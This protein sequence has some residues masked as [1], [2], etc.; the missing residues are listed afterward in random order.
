MLCP[1]FQIPKKV[2]TY[3]MQVE[4]LHQ[5]GK[6]SITMKGFQERCLPRR[7]QDRRRRKGTWLGLFEALPSSTTYMRIPKYEDDVEDLE[8][9]S[10]RGL[11]LLDHRMEINGRGMKRPRQEEEV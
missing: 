3:N 1:V 4:E 5:E 6:S 11:D 8:S 10:G 7:H 2:Y 9:Q